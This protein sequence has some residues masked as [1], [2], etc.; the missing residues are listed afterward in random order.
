MEQAIAVSRR[1]AVFVFFLTP[2]ALP[3]GARKVNLRFGAAEFLYVYSR[4]AIEAVPT[5]LGV[6]FRWH[7]GIGASRAGWF[8][9]EVN[10][11]LVVSSGRRD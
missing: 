5:G 4:P 1:L 3:F 10:T 6:P 8:A 7:R 9:G 2:R 11:V